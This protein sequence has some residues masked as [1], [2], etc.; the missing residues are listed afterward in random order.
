M[1]ERPALAEA[2]DLQPHPEGGWFRETYRSPV[3]FE[4]EGYDGPRASATAIHFLLLP[5]ERSA[6]HTVRSDEIWLWQR[7]G[8]LLLNIGGDEVV[9]GPDVERG[10]LLQAVVPAG[11]SQAARPA[12]DE[13]VLVS[14]V[15]APGFDFAD[16]RLD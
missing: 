8:P 16:F 13:Y 6:P 2:L 12:G 7:G 10:Q 9:L 15:V 1:S 4:P 3:E 5:H 14:C 11:V